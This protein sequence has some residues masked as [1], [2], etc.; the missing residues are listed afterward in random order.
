M[1]DILGKELRVG[2]KVVFPFQDEILAIGNISKI[3]EK[4]VKILHPPLYKK[5]ECRVETSRYPQCVVK[6]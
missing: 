1:T 2:D 6:V 5:S 3:C 4:T